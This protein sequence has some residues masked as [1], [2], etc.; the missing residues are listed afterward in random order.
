VLIGDYLDGVV[1]RI[2]TIAGLTVTT[3]PALAVAPPMAV[4]TD[5]GVSYDAAF[6]RGQDNIDLTVTVYISRGDSLTALEESR[7]YMSGHGAKSIRAAL[8]TSTGGSDTIPNK[9]L[10]AESA[11]TDSNTDA[12]GAGFVVLTVR[13]TGLIPGKE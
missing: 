12:S 4:V 13:A 1:A 11:S 7:L 2:D 5:S 6:G 3:D 8:E 9:T 10:R